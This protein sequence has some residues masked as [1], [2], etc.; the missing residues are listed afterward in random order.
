MWKSATRWAVI[1]LIA[2]AALWWSFTTIDVGLFLHQLSRALVQPLIAAFFLIVASHIARAFRWRAM[3]PAGNQRLSIGRL[4]SAVMIGYAFSTLVPRSGELVR[5]WILSRSSS[6][7]LSTSVTSVFVERLI[8][9]VTLLL[10]IGIASLFAQGVLASVIPGLSV[11]DVLLR[12]L[13]PTLLLACLIVVLVFSPL[14]HRF[15]FLKQSAEVLRYVSSPKVLFPVVAWSIAIWLLYC[16][17]LVFIAYALGLSNPVSLAPAALLLVVISVGVTIAPTP[18]AIGV[19]HT[20][21]Q[22]AMMTLF[23]TSATEAFSFAMIAWVLNYGT[24]VVIG[25]TCLAFEV[26]SGLPWKDVWRAGRNAT[27]DKRVPK[28]DEKHV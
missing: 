10:G 17:P 21:T 23:G 12:I 8:D 11:T 19:Y 4:F 18:G 1:S 16:A 26:R 22:A 24:A 13:V 5:P 28:V 3:L 25:M 27:A 15:R 9:V 7:D 20:F 14:A 2:V 6:V